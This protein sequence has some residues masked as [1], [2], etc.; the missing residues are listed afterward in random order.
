M[1]CL[2]QSSEAVKRLPKRMCMKHYVPMKLDLLKLPF[3]SCADSHVNSHACILWQSFCVT[4]CASD[5]VNEHACYVLQ[6]ARTQK[7][8]NSIGQSSQQLSMDLIMASGWIACFNR[9][10]CMGCTTSTTAVF[11]FLCQI[12]NCW[13]NMHLNMYLRSHLRRCR[14]VLQVM[15]NQSNRSI[16]QGQKLATTCLQAWVCHAAL[17]LPGGTD[18]AASPLKEGLALYMWPAWQHQYWN[19]VNH[20]RHGACMRP[21]NQ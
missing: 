1:F 14:D 12:Q 16:Y 8:K 4:A 11:L 3:Q 2:F 15:V 17:R 20:G 7:G 6:D 5:A 10:C 21:I 19:T 18:V 13:N 9:V